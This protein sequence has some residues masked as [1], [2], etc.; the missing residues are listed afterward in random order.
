MNDEGKLNNK[1]DEDSLTLQALNS[2]ASKS[3]F[4]QTHFDL[5]LWLQGDIQRFIPHQLMIAAWGNFTTDDIHVDVVS[6]LPG[7]RTP[8]I[9]NEKFTG[10]LSNLFKHWQ[11]SHRTP[12]ALNMDKGIFNKHTFICSETRS[13]LKKMKIALVHGI[14]DVR[15]GQDCLY[16]FIDSA[17]RMPSVSRKMVSVLLPYIDAALRQIEHLPEQREPT[18]SELASLLSERETEIMD[19]V[20]RGKTNQDIGMILNISAFTVKNHLQRIFK[21]LDVLN[22]AQAVNEYSRT[23]QA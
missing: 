20:K 13:Q 5:M 8:K 2:L 10:L 11:D 23:L 6:S 12:F 1:L 16:I 17:D 18:P 4:I 21:K 14:K 9:A 15:S 22:R 3:L 7:L 19:W